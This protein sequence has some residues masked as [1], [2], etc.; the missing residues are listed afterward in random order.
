MTRRGLGKGLG[1]LIP[2][3]A[4]V[5][6]GRLEQVPVARI[7][8]NPNQPRKSFDEQTFSELVASVKEFGLVQ[9]VVLRPAGD[10]YELVAGERRWRAAKE[11]GLSN[12]PAIV[13][14]SSDTEALEI[15]LVENIQR[16]NL[17]AIEEATAYKQLI[18]DFEMTQTELAS[19]V[20]K[21]RTALT[22]TLRLLQLPEQIRQHIA[23]GRISSGHARALLSIDDASAQGRLVDRI[24]SDELSVRQAEDVARLWKL[25]RAPRPKRVETPKAFK[26]VARR[27][28]K[29]LGTRVR[30]RTSSKKGRIE[31][32]FDTVDEL[33]RIYRRILAGDPEAAAG[34][35]GSVKGG[36]G[37]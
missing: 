21:S 29:M 10:G 14:S 33:E 7:A 37:E 15:A 27:L 3:L 12:I 32:D 31:I 11:A 16:D 34:V 17:N 2:S 9:P 18:E 13:R 36:R 35:R 8:P 22:N 28:R 23:Q 5:D 4:Q 25:S 1:A 24:M 26:L 20:G 6:S 19:R 30:V